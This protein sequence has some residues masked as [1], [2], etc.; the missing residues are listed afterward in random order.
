MQESRPSDRDANCARPKQRKHVPQALHSEYHQ[1]TTRQSYIDPEYSWGDSAINTRQDNV[2][3]C[4]SR[5]AS[6]LRTGLALMPAITKPVSVPMSGTLQRPQK[7]R[8]RGWPTASAMLKIEGHRYFSKPIYSAQVSFAS[9]VFD[10]DSEDEDDIDFKRAR[11]FT[12][13][14]RLKPSK[15][16]LKKGDVHCSKSCNLFLPI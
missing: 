16:H 11:I 14:L 3:M 2:E 10:D 6:S 1:T 8:S 5:I 9:S 15:L 12:D 13:V 4:D 7:P